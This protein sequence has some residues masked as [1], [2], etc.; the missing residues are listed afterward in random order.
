MAAAFEGHTQIVRALL[1][2]GANPIIQDKDGITAL[3]WALA[4]GH[5]AIVEELQE[6]EKK[7]K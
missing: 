4:Q 6:A 2:G 7:I 3:G 5:T 1:R